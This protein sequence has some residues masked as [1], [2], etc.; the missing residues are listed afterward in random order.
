MFEKDNNYG[1]TKGL[2]ERIQ[3]AIEMNLKTQVKKIFSSLHP[4][5]QA[6]LVHNLD[7]DERKKL[8]EILNDK[9]DPSLL[10]E[11]EGN[12]RKEII[13]YLD[14]NILANLIAK[15]DTDDVVEVLEDCEED[16][17]KETIDAI[18]SSE[19]REDIEEAL[20]YPEDSVGR[21][22]DQNNFIAVPKDW[23]VNEIIK[24]LRK[25]R[26]VPQEFGNVVIVDEYFR[27]VSTASIG[28]ILKNEGKT[29]VSEIMRDPENLKM[30]NADIDQSDA[31]NLFIKYDLKFVPV[32]NH[33][34]IL[35]GVLNSN[36]IIHVINEETKEDMML[37]GN[38]NSDDT[39]YT[40]TLNSTKKRLP[41]LLGSVLTGSMSM[42]VIN[43]FSP[44]IEQFV[45]LSAIMPLAA[46]LSG[47]SGTQTLSILIRNIS[48]NELEKIGITRIIFKQMLVGL[49]DGICL[50]IIVST[51]LYF[52]KHNLKLSIIFGTAIVVLQ[53]LSCLIGTSVP[54]IIKKLNLDPAVGSGTFITALLDTSTSLLLLGMATI[55]LIG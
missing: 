46:N 8:V 53:I 23:D 5:D 28:S 22:M 31:A 7:K 49:L 37:M 18:K 48:S 27:P 50:A 26:N 9:L 52:W 40:T 55:F 20:S 36:D 14:K 51:V 32:V 13:G 47:V 15:L 38:V 11:L 25:N 44:T 16:L 29:L 33:N 12:V 3:N 34:G 10:V 6:E 19:K 41:W 2:V 24:Y 42:L 39:I 4:A 54:L 43:H 45:I 17:T 35:I 1:I 30:I 21:I